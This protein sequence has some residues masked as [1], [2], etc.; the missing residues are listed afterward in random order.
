[1]QESRWNIFSSY[2]CFSVISMRNNIKIHEFF[3][4]VQC[5]GPGLE[6]T[7]QVGGTQE[8]KFKFE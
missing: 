6:V 5:I 1:M 2:F 4:P 3:I 8:I 7:R